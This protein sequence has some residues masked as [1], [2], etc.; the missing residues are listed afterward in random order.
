M[1][2]APKKSRRGLWIL[3]SIAVVF[4][5]GVPCVGITAAVAIPAFTRYTRHAKTAE[6][7]AKL[8][9]LYMGAAVY[10]Q[11][12][13]VGPA[14]NMLTGCTVASA[15]TPSAPSATRAMLGPRPASFDALGFVA[16]DPLYYQYEIVG[17]PGCGHPAGSPLYTFRA[18]GDLD[19]DGTQSLFELSAGSDANGELYR[20]PG[21]FLSNE[22]E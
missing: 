17:V 12:E 11:E 13:H 18:H 8:R 10:Y 7:E 5:L 20:A 16:S 15:I 14:G 22:T 6:A 3:V 4:G 21:L 2:P 9:E 1:Q 19:G